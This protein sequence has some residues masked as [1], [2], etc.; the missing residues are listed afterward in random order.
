MARPTSRVITEVARPYGQSLAS[1]RTSPSSLNVNIPREPARA[2]QLLTRDHE[3]ARRWQAATCDA[4]SSSASSPGFNGSAGSSFAGSTTPTISSALSSLPASLFSSND[5]ETGSSHF[6]LR[7]PYSA[8]RIA[9]H[10]AVGKG[11]TNSYLSGR[12]FL[13]PSSQAT[14]SAMLVT[15]TFLGEL[16]QLVSLHGY[17][18]IGLIVGLESLGLPLPGETILI[19]A[20]IYAAGGVIWAAVFGL[21]GFIFGK[22]L[23]QS[24]LVPVSTRSRDWSLPWPPAR[25][26]AASARTGRHRRRSRRLAAEPDPPPGSAGD[27]IDRLP[28]GIRWRRSDLRHSRLRPTPGGSWPALACAPRATSRRET[29]PPASLAVVRAPRAATW[30]RRRGMQ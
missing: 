11:A 16:Q 25:G 26:Q 28:N 4:G 20:A 23:L 3:T 19:L 29:R 24:C 18:V 14:A 30:L 12:K 7:Q 8:D 2:F 6:C 27:R 10:C 21:G 5:F 1:A 13:C 22:A 17:W 9:R 15:T